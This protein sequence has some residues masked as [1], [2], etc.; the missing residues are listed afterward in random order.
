MQ[1][2]LEKF[3]PVFQDVAEVDWLSLDEAIGRLERIEERRFLAQ[4]HSP[5][6]HSD[7]S[8]IPSDLDF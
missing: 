7:K 6:Q 2:I 1:L 8:A 5:V 4:M 3:Q